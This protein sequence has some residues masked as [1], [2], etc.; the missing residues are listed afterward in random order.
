[1]RGSCISRSRIWLSSIRNCSSMRSIRLLCIWL[2]LASGLPAAGPPTPRLYNLDVCLNHAL[3]RDSFGFIG[4][5]LE[6]LLQEAF[7]RSHSD[8]AHLSALP[9]LLMVYFGNR[10]IKL[11]P[12]PVLQAAYDHPLILQGMG[13]GNVNIQREQ[14]DDNHFGYRRAVSI[15]QMLASEFILWASSLMLASR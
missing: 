14:C 6:Y 5:F 1:M 7:V 9:Q 3:R 4:C 15:G 10:N 13:V 12:Q 8:H 2:L 11:R